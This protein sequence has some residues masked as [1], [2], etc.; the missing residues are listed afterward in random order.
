MTVSKETIVTQISEQ[1]VMSL[2]EAKGALEGLL[3]IMKETLGREEDILISGFGK[4]MVKSKGYRQGRNPRT[5]LPIDLE[6]RQVISFKISNILRKMIAD[7]S[8]EDS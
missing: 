4:F 5:G 8:E 7:P 3:D 1:A 6:S 2:Q